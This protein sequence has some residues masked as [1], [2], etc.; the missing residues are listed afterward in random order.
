[1]SKAPSWKEIR[2]QRRKENFVGRADQLREFSDNFVAEMPNYMVFAVTGEGDVGKSTL[3]KQFEVMAHSPAINAIV[4]T[5]DDRYPTPVSVMGQIAS[6]LAEHDVSH[7]EFDERHK[8]I[9]NCVRRLRATPK[10]H[11]APSTC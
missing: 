8:N 5:C 7:K 2:E 6:E 10:C 11:A 9:A 3:L 1:M 4:I